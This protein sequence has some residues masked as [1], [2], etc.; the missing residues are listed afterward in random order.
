MAQV[1]HGCARTT[2]A[3]LRA[4]QHSQDSLA[5]LAR[6]RGANP[7]TIVKWRAR[8]NVADRRTGQAEPRS[9]SLSAEGESIVV[10]F[11]RTAATASA[12]EHRLRTCRWVEEEMCVCVALRRY[13]VA[14]HA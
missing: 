5:A 1:L 2:E 7:K 11:R 13:A 9:T 4:I 10:A 6:R 14:A 8:G 12:A 3:V